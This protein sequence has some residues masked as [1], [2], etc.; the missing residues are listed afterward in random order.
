MSEFIFITI[1]CCIFMKTIKYNWK[2]SLKEY[3]ANNCKTTNH[4]GTVKY[5]NNLKQ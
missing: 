2:Y 3:K 1:P 4:S 5:L